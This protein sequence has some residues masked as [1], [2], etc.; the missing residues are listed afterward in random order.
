MRWRRALAGIAV[1]LLL[2]GCASMGGGGTEYRA[3]LML[4]RN[5]DFSFQVPEGW[6]PAK[7]SDWTAFGANQRPLQR[8]NAYGK[9]EFQRVGERELAQRP[10]VLISS[11]GSWIDV[12]IGV[13]QGV[14]YSP[15]YVLS[16]GE[17]RTFWENVE[18]AILNG[19]PVTD[20]PKLTLRSMDVVD[21]GPNTTIK[22]QFQREDQRGLTVWTI[23]GL[24]G[25][26]HV[27]TVS[28]CGIPDA[29]N[30]GIGGLD[31][32]ARSFRFE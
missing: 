28:H 23:L 1:L 20:K 16:D 8:M 17:R 21:Y 19:S 14:K 26:R 3:G 27:V 10:A 30:E 11:R 22:L 2:A 31:V 18:R 15:G 5:P 25:A 13:N 7:A 4:H 9:A 29:P 12:S 6:R 32:I 24:Y